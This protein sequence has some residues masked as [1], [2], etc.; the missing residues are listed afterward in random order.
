MQE[1][2][3]MVER[4]GCTRRDHELPCSLNLQI[5][6]PL[7]LHEIPEWP[8]QTLTWM[9]IFHPRNWLR[10]ETSHPLALSIHKCTFLK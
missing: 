6:T 4:M 3:E 8:L 5:Q 2:M 10:Q 9:G 7:K 1:K